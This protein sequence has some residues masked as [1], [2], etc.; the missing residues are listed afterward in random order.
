[1][2]TCSHPLSVNIIIELPSIP[3]AAEP[4]EHQCILQ[5]CNTI[6][7]YSQASAIYIRVDQWSPFI[8][9]Y[10]FIVFFFSFLHL[11]LFFCLL[12]LVWLVVWIFFFLLPN[13]F[14]FLTFSNFYRRLEHIVFISPSLCLSQSC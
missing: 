14:P 9:L 10:N 13:I 12:G 8:S 11:F 6:E 4:R 1:M 5:G 2:S 7:E 3:Q